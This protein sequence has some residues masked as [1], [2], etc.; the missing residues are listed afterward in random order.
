MFLIVVILFLYKFQIQPQVMIF[1]LQRCE[2][3]NAIVSYILTTYMGHKYL[4]IQFDLV[5]CKKKVNIVF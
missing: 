1:F 5:H 3:F 2:V 4:T